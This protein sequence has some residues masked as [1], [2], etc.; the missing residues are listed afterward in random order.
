LR[1]Y[2]A[3]ALVAF[4]ALSGPGAAAVTEVSIQDS[5]N[6]FSPNDVRVGV[7]HSVRWKQNRSNEPHN[8][9]Q[10]RRLFYS[11]A[12]TTGSIDFT[13]KFSAGTFHYYCVFHGFPTGGMDGNVR[14]PVRT[15]AAPDGPPFTVQWAARGTQS[16]NR[17]DVQFRVGSGKWRVWR[18]SST[19]RRAV[20]GRNAKP[21]RVRAGRK[22]SF[23]ARSRQGTN[24]NRVSGWSPVRSFTP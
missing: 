10:D 2:L 13:V 7:G 23:R 4:V 1:R 18:R 15:R 6:S 19:A 12:A 9:R 14:V 16:G 5:T 22:Y 17:F 20:F 24:V 21:V 8:V 11:G 3:A